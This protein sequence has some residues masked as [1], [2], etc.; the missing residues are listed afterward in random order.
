[1]PNTKQQPFPI[2]AGYESQGW[3]E[4]YIRTVYD[5]TL[6][7]FPAKNAVYTPYMLGSGQPK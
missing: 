6:G 7:D 5:C 1:M 3:P 2:H 4:P